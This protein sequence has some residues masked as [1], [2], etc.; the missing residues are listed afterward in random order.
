[1]C[2]RIGSKRND[3]EE[4]FVRLFKS[5]DQLETSSHMSEALRTSQRKRKDPLHASANES[6]RHTSS[7]DSDPRGSGSEVTTKRLCVDK[8]D[9]QVLVSEFVWW[10]FQRKLRGMPFQVG[11]GVQC[12]QRV[13]RSYIHQSAKA[14]T[15]S[16]PSL[17]AAP[18]PKASLVEAA[19]SR[20]I[21][22]RKRK[23]QPW[24]A[25]ESR[26]LFDWVNSCLIMPRTPVNWSFLSSLLTGRSPEEL[27][28]RY[29]EMWEPR[30]RRHEENPWTIANL[31]RLRSLV[32]ETPFDLINW[33]NISHE[34]TED[35][36]VNIRWAWIV[37]EGERMGRHFVLS[38]QHQQKS[39][40][41]GATPSPNQ[42]I[43]VPLR[44]YTDW[45]KLKVKLVFGVYRI[46]DGSDTARCQV[47]AG[48]PIKHFDSIFAQSEPHGGVGSLPV[49]QLPVTLPFSTRAQPSASLQ[50]ARDLQNY[51]K[52]PLGLPWSANDS[53][54]L[55]HLVNAYLVRP[56]T[57]INWAFLATRFPG[58]TAE[59]LE[60]KYW[61][62]W[63]VEKQSLEEYNMKPFSSTDLKRL[64]K[65]VGTTSS[66][67]INWVALSKDFVGV[68]PI[69]VRW[70]W[71]CEEEKLMGQHSAP[72]VSVSP[73]ESSFQGLQHLASALT[74][75]PCH[76][77]YCVPQ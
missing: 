16:P 41:A 69:N 49:K 31:G 44:D 11:G 55:F 27:K 12:Q 18:A 77:T 46:I 4:A 13:D 6:T 64:K 47:A 48:V 50:T 20:Q 19:G 25:D 74:R 42:Q 61:E 66:N 14:T 62:L 5:T 71:I 45:S 43:K 2:S 76:R 8:N 1:M 70:A 24:Y 68:E 39:S 60:E 26:R 73:G 15:L 65:L 29:D 37:E 23:S 40:A 32:G 7:N 28:M 9:E 51:A 22:H 57:I 63:E 38:A 30:K 33:E 72:K 67:L 35:E 58:R 53:S 59:E 21:S 34:F 54:K 75:I 36:P 52:E 3:F 56:Q 10:Q 17:P